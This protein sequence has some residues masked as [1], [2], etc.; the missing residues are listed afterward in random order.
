MALTK[1]VHRYVPRG[2]AVRVFECQ[3]PEVLV[4]GPAGTGKSRAI[5]EKIHM[6]CLLNRRLKCLIVRQTHISLASTAL[7]T[8]ADHVAIEA[9]L[10][11]TVTYYGGSPKEPAGYKYS[12]GSFIGFAGMDKP[13]KIMSSEYDIIYVQEAIELSL[14]GW[15]SLSTRARNG[16]SSFQQLI[17]DTNPERPTHWLYQRCQLGTTTLIE[18]RHEDNPRLYDDAGNITAEGAVYLARLDNLTGIR[19]QRLRY[20]KWVGAEGLIYGDFDMSLHLIDKYPIPQDWPRIWGLDFGWNDPFV[21]QM[22]A[23]DP[24][25]RLILYREFYRSHRLVEHHARDILATVAP[26]GVWS[27]PR[28]Y[29]V[30]ADHDAEDRA[31]FERHLGIGTTP[32]KKTV[33]DGLQAVQSRLKI[34]GDGKPR[35]YVM[36]GSLVERDQRRV[37]MLRPTCFVDEVTGY[38]WNEAKDTPV[39]EDDHSMDTA[40]YVVAQEDLRVPFA[41]EWA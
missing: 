21:C 40:R 36:R 30:V 8:Y 27:E 23:K 41:M 39:K 19:K 1:M 5:L 29:V 28:P 2:A 17:A 32:A 13:T 25:G 31:T 26:G 38:V 10:D 16:R 24:D 9:I 14:T 35:L 18:S 12:N 15:E 37:E 20:G 6:M 3:D 34:Q 7:A 11:G 22:W 33:S 4:S